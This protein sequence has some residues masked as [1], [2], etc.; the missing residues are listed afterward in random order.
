MSVCA[1]EA[2]LLEGVARDALQKL[3]ATQFPSATAL[4]HLLRGR[5]SIRRFHTEPAELSVIEQLLD[6]ARWA[7]SGH[8]T[9]PL[10]YAVLSGRERIHGLAGHAIDHFRNLLNTAPEAAKALGAENLV[11]SWEAGKDAVLRHAPQ[12]IIAYGPK[13]HPMLSGSA[14]I[15][16]TQVELLATTMGLGAC[17]A[18][19]V[20][21]A[22]AAHAPLRASLGLAEGEA[23]GGA[24]M[25]GRPAVKYQS[26]PPRK[27]LDIRWD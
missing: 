9:Q 22:S 25:I 16:L 13:Q 15:A 1:S 18:G 26:I 27:P 11:R 19:Y 10:R 21:I 2:L 17:W 20:M 24:L 4:A 5:R 23:V 12:L 7:P 6:A 8:N 14:L 3:D